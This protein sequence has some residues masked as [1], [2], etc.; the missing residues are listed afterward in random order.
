MA[1]G[2]IA[3]LAALFVMWRSIHSGSSTDHGA[4]H[5]ADPA[6][7]NGPAPAPGSPAARASKQRA[8]VPG[9][10]LPRPRPG[11]PDEA[12]SV[13][14]SEEHAP[15]TSMLNKTHLEYGGTQL[16][17]QAKAVEPLVRDC[18]DKANAT[19]AKPTGSAM[20]TYVVAKHGDKY[21]VEDTS[22]DADQTTLQQESL[23]TCLSETAKAMKFVGLPREAEALVVTRSVK[24]ENGALTEYKHV[25]FSYLR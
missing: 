25:G 18:V 10:P 19:G 16:R 12:P 11:E 23:V 13:S 20:L 2:G 4:T 14:A 6:T 1:A 15:P 5:T 17:T 7:P 22:F 24:V 21:E 3:L 9:V 8:N